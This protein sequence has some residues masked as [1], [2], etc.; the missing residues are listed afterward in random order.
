MS[1]ISPRP[2]R[3][4][5]SSSKS[6]PE[7]GEGAMLRRQHTDEEMERSHHAHHAIDPF[8]IYGPR[9]EQRLL[10][11]K[12]RR[13]VHQTVIF[14]AVVALLGATLLYLRRPRA[15]VWHG[16]RVALTQPPGAAPVVAEDARG[17]ALLVP[18]EG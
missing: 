2:S 5:K 15:P 13:A 4:P 6:Q 1:V 3:T 11:A 17:A 10:T 12:R 14:L 16:M 9:T 7:D 18:T 8:G